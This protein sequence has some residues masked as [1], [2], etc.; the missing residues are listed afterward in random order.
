MSKVGNK[1]VL[2][3]E[4]VTVSR[5]GRQI[6]VRG[7]LGEMRLALP[8]SLELEN[9]GK[10]LRVKRANDEI[11]TRAMHGT[12][13]R[14]LANAITGT[15]TGFFKTLE[16][17]GTGYRAQLE[18]NDLVLALGYSHPVRFTSPEGIKIEAKE[19]RITVFGVDK[20]LVGRTADKIKHFK[21]PDSY[22]GKGIRYAGEK[23]RLKPGKAAAKAV[24]G[25]K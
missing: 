9:L 15:S 1:P 24:P 7:P 22:K 2:I 18:G 21:W 5:E 17:V 25:G 10:E 23:L 8:E 6:I 12:M 4:G 13:A 11:K 14:L 16:V 20:E 3:K 19:N